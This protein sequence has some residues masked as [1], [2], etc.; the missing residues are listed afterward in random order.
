MSNANL[1][2]EKPKAMAP[3]AVAALILGVSACSVGWAYGIPGIIVGAIG[4]NI[5]GKA[6]AAFDLN[7]GLYRGERLIAEGL[8]W[9]RIGLIQGIILTVAYILYFVVIV[10][11]VMGRYR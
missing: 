8:K 1:N 5:A 4:L 11:L 2:Q 3:S 7:P 6:K 9:S 10:G